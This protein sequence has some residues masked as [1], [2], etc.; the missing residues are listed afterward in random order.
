MISVTFKGIGQEEC[1]WCQKDKDV[2]LVAFSDNSFAGPMCW[3]D[4]KRAIRLKVGQ[5][6][7]VQAQP[8][9]AV[10]VPPKANAG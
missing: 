7:N 4:L 2:F 10:P 5:T 6:K 3:N 8:A 1:C 9:Q